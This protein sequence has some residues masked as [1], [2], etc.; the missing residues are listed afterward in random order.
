L[1]SPGRRRRDGVQ[2]VSES[3]VR[4]VGEPILSRSSIRASGHLFADARS[5]RI[6]VGEL[7]ILN[8]TKPGNHVRYFPSPTP[9]K[10]GEILFDFF[11]K[12]VAFSLKTCIK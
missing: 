6:D 11:E 9:R 5:Q 7:L 3:G 4:R 10:S 2:R 1:G 8:L 12:N